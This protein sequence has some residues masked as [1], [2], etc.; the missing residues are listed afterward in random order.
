MF[1]SGPRGPNNNGGDTNSSS[2]PTATNIQS[3][4][5]VNSEAAQDIELED[6]NRLFSSP[7]IEDLNEQAKE[8]FQNI[9]P[10]SSISSTETIKPSSSKIK[11]ESVLPFTE[12]SEKETTEIIKTPSPF[13]LEGS[14]LN[15]EESES[16]FPDTD[17]KGK[18]KAI[19]T[20]ID[21]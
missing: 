12:L 2:T 3:R 9:S 21:S 6:R 15:L 11:L 14:G 4:S 7:S 20:I 19:E 17:F 5:V 1:S 10:S 13:P 18:A 16:L 8:S